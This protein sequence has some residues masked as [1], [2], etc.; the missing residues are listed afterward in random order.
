MVTPGCN[1]VAEIFLDIFLAILFFLHCGEITLDLFQ[2][3]CSSS[4]YCSNCIWGNFDMLLFSC[5]HFLSFSF[6]CLF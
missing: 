6:C 5:S 1:S 2:S 3:L 4:S